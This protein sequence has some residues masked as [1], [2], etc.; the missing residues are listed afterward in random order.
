M[1]TLDLN[2]YTSTRLNPSQ[3]RG[4]ERIR[5]ILAA[6][7]KAFRE[8]G[9]DQSTTNDIAQTAHIP[10]G[11][12][13]R[14]FENKEEIILA[15]IE[16]YTEDVVDLFEEVTQNPLLPQLSWK[17]IL[18]IVV[19]TW[20]SH[21]RIN[22]A[23]NIVYYVRCN[24]RLAKQGQQKW[25]KVAPAFLSILK[26]RDSTITSAE[27]TVYLQL[28]WST[29]EFSAAAGEEGVQQAIDI[30]AASLDQRKI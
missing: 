7:L 1:H 9:I 15:L 3:M 26:T 10:I 28:T 21:S 2:R 13:Y 25:R 11:S 4:K 22:D 18:T 23:P 6:A 24:Q 20:I 16:L 12:I 29:V 14:Y 27:A 17:E 5:V 30:I 19:D 8:K